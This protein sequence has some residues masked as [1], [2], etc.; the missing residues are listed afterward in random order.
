[1]IIKTTRIVSTTISIRNGKKHVDRVDITSDGADADTDA[2]LQDFEKDAERTFDEFEASSRKL[3]ESFDA[4]VRRV[5]DRVS[6][7]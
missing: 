5:V 3:W 2:A 6:R 7:R 4:A 1:M